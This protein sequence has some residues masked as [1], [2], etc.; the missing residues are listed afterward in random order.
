[1]LGLESVDQW[2]ASRPDLDRHIV[3]SAVITHHLKVR[4]ASSNSR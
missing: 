2:L 1:M 3:L 4:N